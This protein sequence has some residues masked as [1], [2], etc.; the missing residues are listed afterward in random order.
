[1]SRQNI[2]YDGYPAPGADAIR[3]QWA[4]D[5]FGPANYQANGYNMSAQDF[6]MGRIETIGASALSQSGNFY[7]KILY[8]AISGAAETRAPG[9]NSVNIRWYVAG[10]NNEVANNSNLAVEVVQLRGYG[11]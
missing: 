9:F 3:N 11:L 8:P 1:M 7:V 4:G 10:N 6:S 2:P 5:H